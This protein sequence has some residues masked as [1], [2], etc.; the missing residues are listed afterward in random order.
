LRD[1]LTDAELRQRLRLAARERRTTL[2]GW[3]ATGQLIGRV[4]SAAA[5]GTGPAC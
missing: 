2:T 5:A 1:W 4:L 3:A